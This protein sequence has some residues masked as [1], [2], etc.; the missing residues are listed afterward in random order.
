MYEY[1]GTLCRRPFITMKLIII[2]TIKINNKNYPSVFSNKFCL[3]KTQYAPIIIPR[4]AAD[5]SVSPRDIKSLAIKIDTI[6]I[7]IPITFCF[8]F[9]TFY[10]P[11]LFYVS[12]TE[13]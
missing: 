8:A 11:F 6:I 4:A 13:R 9:L 5:V 7:N 10:S 12:L 1:F 3:V 2:K